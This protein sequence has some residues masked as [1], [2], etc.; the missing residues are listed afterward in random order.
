[1]TGSTMSA[2]GTGPKGE[3]PL[4]FPFLERSLIPSGKVRLFLHKRGECQ[5]RHVRIR[6]MRAKTILH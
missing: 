5:G 3:Y 2:S 1:M 4:F 6:F